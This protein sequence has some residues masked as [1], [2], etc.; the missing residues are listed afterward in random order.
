MPVR[1]S[2][3]HL[4]LTLLMALAVLSGC[5]SIQSPAVRELIDRQAKKTDSASQASAAFVDQTKKRIEAYN[6]GLADLNAS[7]LNLRS[8]ESVLALTLASSQPVATKEGID[9]RAFGYQAGLLYLDTQA[10][11]DKAVADQFKEDFAAMQALS[12]K[13]AAS[14]ASL[15]E[16]QT[17]LST[18]A[19]QSSVA[20]ADP[21]LLSAILAQTPVSTE[22][23][24]KVI[25]RSKQ[26][27]KAL[28]KVSG[29]GPLQGEA[30][31][32]ARGY[33]QDLIQLLE[34]TK[35]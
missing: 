3:P 1:L 18:Y 14:W 30:A 29:F 9:A 21:A 19:K 27:N 16:L 23:V 26:V 35:Q 6:K 22:D 32:N 11:L 17:Q 28:E 34:S 5:A 7:L 8:Q 10:G 13:I 31:G 25:Q 24:D 12:E 33:F 4:L 2:S 20:S 15:Q